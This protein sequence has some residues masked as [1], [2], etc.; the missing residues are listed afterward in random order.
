MPDPDFR[1][2]QFAVSHDR[3][4]M[5]VGTDGVLLGAWAS[6]EQCATLLDVGT[7]SGL[8]A[9]MLAQRN[10]NAKV[11]AID[12]DQ[13]AC[14]Q[15]RDNVDASPYTKRINV[16]NTS[17]QQFALHPP[18]LYDL[19]VSNPPFFTRSL[20]PPDAG[21]ADARHSVSLS[22]EALIRDAHRCL[23]PVGRL[24]LILPADRLAEMKA[25]SAHAGFMLRRLTGVVPSPG[26]PVRRLLA[27]LSLS[28]GELE[29]TE[30]LLE[31]SRHHYSP[32]YIEL[33]RDFY[34]NL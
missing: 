19:V 31:V 4:A 8:I 23:S 33:V 13:N 6:V 21:R 18:R 29:V 1:F 17:F 22:L 24:A 27:E 32:A 25:L 2:K 26:K 20:L 9:L 14:L 16:I 5:K 11:T 34:L 10:R 28:P 3:C 30:L 15:A 7:G 12:I